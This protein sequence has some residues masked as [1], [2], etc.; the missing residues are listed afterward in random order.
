MPSN[1][2]LQGHGSSDTTILVGPATKQPASY[3]FWGF[4]FN[5]GVTMSGLADLA[6]K[7]IDTL[8]QTVLSTAAAGPSSKI[9]I[10]RVNWDLGTG[11][12]ISFSN[13]DRLL[14]ANS[15]FHQAINKLN[16]NLA[17][18]DESGV[19]AFW[20]QK[21]TNFIFQNNAISWASS[22]NAFLTINGGIF[23]G[24]HFTR[25][26]SDKIAVNASNIGWLNGDSTDQPITIGES[27][28]RQMGRQIAVEFAQNVVI[29]S[30]IFDVS[31]GI[32][33]HNFN[34]GETINSEGGGANNPQQ[35]IGTVTAA[36]WSSVSANTKCAGTCNWNY[37]PA[38]AYNSGSMIAI[39]SGQGWGQ[40]RQI[41]SKNNNTFTVSPNWKVLPAAG[42]QFAIFV[43]SMQN[44][45]I[46]NNIMQGNP[47]GILLYA[48]GFYNVSIITNSLTD[49]GG[50]F[51]FSDQ[52]TKGLEF[53][54]PKIGAL[55]N[56]EVNGNSV[57]NTR[58]L[59]P[60]YIVN[61]AALL[62][63][64]SIWGT[65]LDS[66]EVRNNSVTGKPGTPRYDFN[67]GQY[68][69]SVSYTDPAGPYSPNGSAYAIVGTIFQ[70][71]SCT[72]CPTFYSL[73]GGVADTV[74]WNSSINGATP[75]P[76]G[77][78]VT[79]PVVTDL[80]LTNTTSIGTIVGHD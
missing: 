71:N 73:S 52:D 70:G 69:N 9:F 53:A 2:V 32:L 3:I 47:R 31:D 75:Y 57:K 37:S 19:G 60:A 14:I 21:L 61:C 38:S 24:N 78:L 72:N 10:Q 62:D 63:P 30:N 7:N 13:L 5:A 55:R 59:Y 66:I 49:N 46:R 22:G 36:T 74:I 79:T 45:V 26:A 17:H 34:D 28:Q 48:A 43:P 35:D 40:W 51:L 50:I 33:L 27:V 65:G 11:Q 4:F 68:M 77:T 6:I 20:L 56:I 58:G 12:Y 54:S 41:I 44:T 29:Q 67:D 64:N 23:E 39:V 15:T 8:S 25:S 16:P 80:K 18:P 1:V 42:D 76:P